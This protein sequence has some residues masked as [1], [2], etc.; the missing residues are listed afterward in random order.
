MATTGRVIYNYRVNN[1]VTTDRMPSEIMTLYMPSPLN[2]PVH[3]HPPHPDKK[4]RK[5]IKRMMMDELDE[6]ADDEDFIEIQMI[7]EEGEY[8][9]CDRYVPRFD[10]KTNRCWWEWIEYDFDDNG[11]EMFDLDQIREDAW[12]AFEEENRSRSQRQE[13]WWATQP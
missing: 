1:P 4:S 12:L 9:R 11:E 13:D 3:K 6:D 8:R 10:A 2:L 7:E 5:E